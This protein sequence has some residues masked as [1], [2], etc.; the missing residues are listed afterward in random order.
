MIDFAVLDAADR[1][2]RFDRG[3]YHEARR[4]RAPALGA[5]AAAQGRPDQRA[6]DLTEEQL[7]KILHVI[8]DR[9]WIVEGDLGFDAGGTHQRH[10][11]I[12]N[13]ALGKGDHQFVFR[14]H[15]LWNSF[16]RG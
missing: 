6:Q 3:A 14:A 8:T 4:G 7:N 16:L 9:K 15:G 1:R 13:S 12:E 11:F 5:E 2:H 10:G